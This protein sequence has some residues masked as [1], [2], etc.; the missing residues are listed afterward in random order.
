MPESKRTY[1][2]IKAMLALKH[3]TSKELA[4]YLQINPQTV[5]SWATNSRQPR[6]DELYAIAEFLQIG[7]C[8]LLEL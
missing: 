5:S 8:E 2:R 4:E 3:K 1:N 6:L 7:P